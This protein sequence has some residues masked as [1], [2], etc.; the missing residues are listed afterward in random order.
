MCEATGQESLG[1]VKHHHGSHIRT[2][3]LHGRPA[4]LF[5]FPP[6]GTSPLVGR[7]L[8]LT[9]AS[10]QTR[11]ACVLQLLESALTKGARVWRGR[12]KSR[13]GRPAAGLSLGLKPA[14]P[15]CWNPRRPLAP[16]RWRSRSSIRLIDVS[17]VLQSDRR[18]GSAYKLRN[19]LDYI[20]Q[21]FF[22]S[23]FPRSLKM[24]NFFVACTE[25]RSV[26]TQQKCVT[27]FITE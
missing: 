21:C 6:A 14:R 1:L 17:L 23:F 9:W 18:S 3:E 4:A 16:A 26:F 2:K 5:E 15:A 20:L 10:E 13:R 25:D 12:S 11:S 24:F 27:V 22:L 19:I 8:G 7:F